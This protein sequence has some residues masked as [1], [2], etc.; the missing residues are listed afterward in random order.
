MTALDKYQI[1]ADCVIGGVGTKRAVALLCDTL[2]NSGICVCM[3]FA[4][5][6]LGARLRRREARAVT[7]ISGESQ[8][9]DALPTNTA[10]IPHAH[11]SL[12]Q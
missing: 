4:V 2:F 12:V 5:P 10:A 7:H 3:T 8:G 9:D 11:D 1:E 6:V